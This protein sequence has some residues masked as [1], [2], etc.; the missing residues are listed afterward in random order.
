MVWPGMTPSP[1]WA[2]PVE[3]AGDRGGARGCSGGRSLTSALV[4]CAVSGVACCG[5]VSY[6][7][8]TVKARDH[9]MVKVVI[10]R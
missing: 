6:E 1:V 8:V 5:S 3:E 10:V 9:V 2:V 4:G 7:C